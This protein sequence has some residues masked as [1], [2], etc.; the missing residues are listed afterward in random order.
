[1]DHDIMNQMLF[2]ITH[3][4]AHE[5]APNFSIKRH[6][7]KTFLFYMIMS[8]GKCKFV[9]KSVCHLISI[10]ISFFFYSYRLT[11]YHYHIFMQ[12][13]YFIQKLHRSLRMC[14]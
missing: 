9:C 1:M 7:L 12:H 13:L 4:Y 5:V 10:S 14:L 3:T 2:G 8:N 6:L 11:G